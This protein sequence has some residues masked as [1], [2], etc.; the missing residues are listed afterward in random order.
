MATEPKTQNNTALRDTFIIYKNLV[1]KRVGSHHLK[2]KKM[3]HVYL[4]F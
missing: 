2:V 1:E 4:T 3:K